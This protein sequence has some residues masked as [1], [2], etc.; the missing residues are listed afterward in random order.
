MRMQDDDKSFCE[1]LF[2][3]AMQAMHLPPKSARRF[4]LQL[5]ISWSVIQ[6]NYMHVSHHSFALRIP[7]PQF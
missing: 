7:A 2:A 3:C 5:S 6:Y 4:R 1:S